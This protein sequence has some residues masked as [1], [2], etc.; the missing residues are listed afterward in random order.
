MSRPVLAY[1]VNSLNPGGT[2]KLVVEM[3]R[4]FAGEFA[5]QVF[6]LDEPGLWAAE[7]RAAGVAVHGLWRQPGLDLRMP[8]RLG[9]LFRK[10]GVDLIHAHQCTAWFYAALAQYFHRKTPLLLEEHGRFFP[11]VDRP[12]RRFVN[13]TLIRPQTQRFVAVS[14]DVRERLVRYEGLDRRKIEVVY[15]GVP[16]MPSIPASTRDR[17]RAEFGFRPDD[18][19]IGTIGRFDPIKDLGMLVGGLAAAYQRDPR[20]AGLLVGDGPERASIATLVERSGL[21]DR[22]CM[23]GF[24]N[25]ACKLAQCMDLFALTSVSEGTSMALLEAMA[26]GVPVVVTAVGGNPELVIE[27]QTGWVVASGNTRALTAAMLDAAADAAV[28]NRYAAAGRLRY[29]ELF[30]VER[31]VER[32]RGIYRSM[33]AVP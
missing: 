25:D 23:T 3:S 7:L 31:M 22:V 12:L 5:V 1:V 29:A 24:R 21:A 4:A 33:I 16:A 32:Y 13:R 20:I 18:F 14:A 27:G 26:A 19:V 30:T 11:E 28:R 2:E 8:I 9:R 17:L 15:N 10:V 6:C